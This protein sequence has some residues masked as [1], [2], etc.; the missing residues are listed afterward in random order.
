MYVVSSLSA[1]DSSAPDVDCHLRI[2]DTRSSA[3]AQATDK[4]VP[5]PQPPWVIAHRG[6]AGELPEHTAQAYLQGIQE[7][8]DFIE[9]DMTLT[10]DCQVVCR[11]E[12]DLN[13]TTDAYVKFPQ[14]YGAYFIDDGGPQGSG[15][16][17][18]VGI[19]TTQ[20]TLAEIKTLQAQARIETRAFRNTNYDLAGF[21]VITLQEYIDIAKAAADRVVG[22]IPEVKHP[23]YF[24]RILQTNSSACANNRTFSQI[25]LEIL[26]KNGYRGPFGTAQWYAQPAIIQSFEID[27]LKELH[28]KTDIAL[29]QLIDS[30]G[31]ILGDHP[32]MT[33]AEMVTDAGLDAIAR[34]AQL[35]APYKSYYA[36]NNASLGNGTVPAPGYIRPGVGGKSDRVDVLAAGLK[37]N[38][39]ASPWT[40][41]MENQFLAWDYQQDGWLEYEYVYNDVTFKNR[42]TAQSFIGYPTD[43]LPTDRPWI[44]ADGGASG[45][46]PDSTVAA[47]QYAVDQGANFIACNVTATLDGQ[48]ICSHDIN[49][50][51]TTDAALKFPNLA[52]NSSVNNATVSMVSVGD[53]TLAQVSTLRAKQLY[54][55]NNVAYRDPNYNGLFPVATFSNFLAVAKNASHPVGVYVN[56]LSPSAQSAALANQNTTVEDLVLAA[57]TSAG[58]K[59]GLCN[60]AW[61]RTPVMIASV[62]ATS[63]K[64]LKNKQTDTPL[65]VQVVSKMTTAAGLDDIASYARAISPNKEFLVPAL[66]TLDK[67]LRPSTGQT[68]EAYEAQA[69]GLLVLPYT[70]RPALPLTSP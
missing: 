5:F 35:I 42:T 56:I 52:Q 66:T 41:R 28:N 33:Y 57:L 9:C 7:G 58:Y 53:L 25:C 4:R 29:V 37:R 59:G 13:G 1:S 3:A 46:L 40:Y 17:K 16:T 21:K 6:N 36:P 44:I 14:Y 65:V 8:A 62:E 70:F 15:G 22:I 12:P 30:P 43:R 63:L 49:L 32:N 24:N 19:L 31:N 54:A 26:Q 48:L 68:G 55:P 61:N 27:N 10:K 47:F 60:G 64:A 34:Y 69:V 23:T 67:N 39:P 20:M 18:G 45:V 2:G 11:H 38:M 50:G 51:P